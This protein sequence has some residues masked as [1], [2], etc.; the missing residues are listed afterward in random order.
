MAC[1]RWASPAG[2][3]APAAVLAVTAAALVGLSA[4][5]AAGVRRRRGAGPAPRLGDDTP[6][7]RAQFLETTNLLLVLLSALG[8]GFVAFGAV[9]VGV[10]R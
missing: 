8:V 7:S 4:C 9:V 10:C 2:P 3:Y 5:L 6:A 1:G